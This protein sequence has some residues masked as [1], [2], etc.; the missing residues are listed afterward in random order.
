[1]V[2]DMVEVTAALIDGLEAD[3]GLDPT[4]FLWYWFLEMKETWLHVSW[5][6]CL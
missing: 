4:E 3:I 5:R 2:R 6:C 1:M